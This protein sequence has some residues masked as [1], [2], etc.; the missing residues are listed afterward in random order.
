M[1][2]ETIFFVKVPRVYFEW[3][4]AKGVTKEHVQLNHPNAIEVKHHTE[5]YD[6]REEEGKDAGT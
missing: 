3:I 6:S 5:F 4:P 2:S 1:S